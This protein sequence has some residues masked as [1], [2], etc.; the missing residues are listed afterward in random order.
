MMNLAQSRALKTKIRNRELCWGAWTQTVHE[1]IVQI[2]S[3]LEYDF[4]VIDT[5]HAAIGERE[6]A[7]ACQILS[8][9]NTIPYV[10]VR[11]KS[12]SS[13]RISLD[14]GAGGIIAPMVESNDDIKKVLEWAKFPPNGIRGVG[15]C[16]ANNLGIDLK[17]YVK[18]ADE[19]LA[20][21]AQIETKKGME[22]LERILELDEVDGAF[23]GPY[24]LS[25][26]YGVTGELG[27]DIVR[28]AYDR[29]V[30]CCA[31]YKKG[32][33][34]HIISPDPSMIDKSVSDGFTWGALSLDLSSVESVARTMKNASEKVKKADGN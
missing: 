16:P 3:R 19:S 13:I 17:S 4:L 28:K 20:T 25:C 12:L 7:K 18:A 23:I 6:I 15:Y 29:F 33:G 30:E 14:L 10:R 21:I 22:N 2:Y 9:S 31:K 34:I 5:E 32:A 24:D 11:E 27:H 1:S 8:Q 26:S